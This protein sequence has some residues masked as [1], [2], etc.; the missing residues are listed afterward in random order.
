[1]S[2][3]VSGGAGYIGSHVVL[4]LRAAGVP[5][6]VLDDLSTGAR[7]LLPSGTTLV[8]ASIADTACVAALL[9]KHDVDSV[10]HFAGS[11]VVK[12]SVEH[13]IAYY[14]NNVT[15]SLRFLETCL[16]NGVRTFLFSSSAAVYGQPA[17]SKVSEDTPLAPI[18]PYGAT[19]LMFERI[20]Q[21]VSAAHGLRYAILRYFNVAGADPAGRTGQAMPGA[22]HLIKVACEVA[23]D[24]RPEIAIFGTDYPTPDG[25]CIRDYIHVSDLADIHVLALRR[26]GHGFDS[27]V[28]NCGYGRG[29]SVREVLDA[30]A[31][32]SGRSLSI[33]EAP[34]RPG[35][36]AALIAD[37]TRLGRLL[38]W[39][40]LHDDLDQIVRSAL[41]WERRLEGRRVNARLGPNVAVSTAGMIPPQALSE[42]NLVLP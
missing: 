29:Y 21:D 38:D 1:M 32:V 25:T 18:A 39:R 7:F 3:L 15:R 22:T 10:I 26:L 27:F 31:R 11:V 13:P 37:T 30:V 19:K 2:I 36:A 5:V 14:K 28:V 12:D 6:V 35:D 20:L 17:S 23:V 16:S 9:Q 34:R 4:A 8:E 42:R 33:R 41:V 24:L 40:P